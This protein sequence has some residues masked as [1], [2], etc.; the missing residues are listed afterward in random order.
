MRNTAL[1]F[2]LSSSLGGIVFIIVRVL[3]LRVLK[4]VSADSMDVLQ[5]I[6]IAKEDLENVN[7]ILTA[8]AAELT[9]ANEQL[10]QRYE[11]LRGGPQFARADRGNSERAKSRTGHLKNNQRNDFRNS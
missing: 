9:R 2:L 7:L 11:E 5:E 10:E 3:P 6:K 4:L 1:L 8:Q